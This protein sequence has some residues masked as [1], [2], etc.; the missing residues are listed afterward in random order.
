MPRTPLLFH[1]Y[2]ANNNSSNRMRIY[3]MRQIAIKLAALI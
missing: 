3:Q 1:A 2:V